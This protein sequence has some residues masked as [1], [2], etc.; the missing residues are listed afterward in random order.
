MPDKV[1]KTAENLKLQSLYFMHRI[2]NWTDRQSGIPN[3]VDK[4]A[5]NL[6]LQSL[7]FSVRAQDSQLDR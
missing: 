4:I 5:E 6:K 7:Y 1:Y 3:I 2:P